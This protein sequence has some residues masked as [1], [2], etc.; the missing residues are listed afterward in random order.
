MVAK[1]KVDPY[2]LPDEGYAC[3]FAVVRYSRLF[4]E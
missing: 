1:A 2:H 4:A 3:G